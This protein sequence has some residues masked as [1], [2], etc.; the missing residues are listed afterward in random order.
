MAITYVNYVKV[1]NQALSA[2]LKAEF[3]VT[4]IRYYDKFEKNELAKKSEYIRFYYNGDEHLDDLALGNARSY[5]YTLSLYFQYHGLDEQDQFEAIVTDR[6]EHLY[7]LLMQNRAYEPSGVYKWHHI[8]VEES[9]PVVWGIE[10]EHLE[11][12]H[13]EMDITFTR[14]NTDN[15]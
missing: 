4:P 9:S 8:I 15:F 5:K 6:K 12:A 2:L 11:V 14:T 13:I 1:I 3:T 10:E 7:N